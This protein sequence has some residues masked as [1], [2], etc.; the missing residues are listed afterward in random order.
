MYIRFNYIYSKSYTYLLVEEAHPVAILIVAAVPLVV[1]GALVI[2]D[3]NTGI[4]DAL[5]YKSTKLI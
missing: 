2:G 3:R 5:D 1:P 4:S